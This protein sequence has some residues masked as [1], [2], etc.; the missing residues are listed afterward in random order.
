MVVSVKDILFNSNLLIP[1]ICVI[2][3]YILI[4]TAI[5]YG[6]RKHYV[7]EIIKSPSSAV[8]LLI[9]LTES[10]YYIMIRHFPNINIWD[11][12]IIFSIESVI[13]GI[14]V[15]ISL[16]DE[17]HY[18]NTFPVTICRIALYI[19]G[20]SLILLILEFIYI[21]FIIIGAVI[22]F[23]AAVWSA[24]DFNTFKKNIIFWRNRI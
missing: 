24:V 23:G 22:L 21:V 17:K 3:T 11:S 5:I 1:K 18:A 15:I 8:F 10:C 4:I 9:I 13:F 7:S 16:I 2:F 6:S 19:I 14:G 12:R 20:L